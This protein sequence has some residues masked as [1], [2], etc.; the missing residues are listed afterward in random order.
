MSQFK[1]GATIVFNTTTVGQDKL[2]NSSMAV[3]LRPAT[4]MCFIFVAVAAVACSNTEVPVCPEG[5]Y[6]FVEYQLF[7][8]RGGPGGEVV[9]DAAWEAFLEDT[10]TPRFPDGLTVVDGKGQWRGSEG[11]IEKERSKLLI[12]LAPPGDNGMRL[13]D[14]ISEEY[15]S[16]FDQES[17][18]RT[19]NESCVSFS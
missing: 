4:F 19:V 7:M 11:S 12:I 14:E 13:I 3:W 16:R 18:L 6:R 2:L 8:G 10:V 5:T 15:E 9:D 1:D 17:V